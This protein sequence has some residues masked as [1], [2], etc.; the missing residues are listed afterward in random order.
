[1][2][3]KIHIIGMVYSFKSKGILNGIFFQ[4]RKVFY[5]SNA[6]CEPSSHAMNSNLIWPILKDG[7]TSIFAFNLFSH[8]YSIKTFTVIL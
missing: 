6:L 1:M 4:S 3:Q 2:A 5:M 7:L 8:Y